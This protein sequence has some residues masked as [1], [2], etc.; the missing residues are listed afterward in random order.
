MQLQNKNPCFSFG[1]T[2]WNALVPPVSWSET[3]IGCSPPPP[4]VGEEHQWT[5]DK[6][7]R[8]VCVNF[9]S[10]QKVKKKHKN[11]QLWMCHPKFELASRFPTRFRPHFTMPSPQNPSF[12]RHLKGRQAGGSEAGRRLFLLSDALARMPRN[13]PCP[14]VPP[15]LLPALW[16]AQI[17]GMAKATDRYCLLDVFCILSEQ[18]H[19]RFTDAPRACERRPLLR[20]VD[21]QH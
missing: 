1:Q 19:F 16:T 4:R 12:S 6:G 10:T 11:R 9:I 3:S 15:S 18:W 14:N 8:Y 2:L 13:T 20:G 5:S 17:A 21:A 7:R